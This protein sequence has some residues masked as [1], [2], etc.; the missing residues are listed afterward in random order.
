MAIQAST[1]A[2]ESGSLQDRFTLGD[3]VDLE[4]YPIADL[5]TPEGRRTVRECRAQFDDAVSCHLPGFVRE[6]ALKQILRDVGRVSHLQHYYR[7]DRGAYD[8]EDPKAVSQHRLYED[9][10]PRGIRHRRHLAWLGYDDFGLEAPLRRLYEW[11]T[12]TRFIAEVL[13]EPILYSVDD[14]LMGVLVNI[15]NEGDELGWHVD[16]HD[17]AITLLLQEAAQGGLYQYVPN[18]A[19]GDENFDLVPGLF[20]GD[21]SAVRTVP[22]KPGSLV[23]FRGRNTLHRVTKV[24][25]DTPRLLALFAYD[26]VPHRQFGDSFR[27]NVLGRT[28]ERAAPGAAS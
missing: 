8:L 15:S 9:G 19:P 23:L 24:S 7:Q 1:S 22:M 5:D 21:Q 3:I 6:S 25:G 11:P 10:D 28:V 20:Q 27:R 18:T 4:R 16:S 17:F 26:N 14:A 12:L 2:I 13:G